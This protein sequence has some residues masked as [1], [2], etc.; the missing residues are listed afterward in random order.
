M[1]FL[2]SSALVIFG[3]AT[4][5]TPAVASDW[6][7]CT[8]GGC[9][10]APC[11]ANEGF[12]RIVSKAIDVENPAVGGTDGAIDKMKEYFLAQV[13]GRVDQG[14]IGRCSDAQESEQAANDMAMHVYET[15]NGQ[16]DRGSVDMTPANRV[17][18]GYDD[19]AANSSDSSGGESAVT[20][21]VKPAPTDKVA[22]RF[23]ATCAICWPNRRATA[24]R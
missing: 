3:T 8:V 23:L 6:R 22:A 4:I 24:T 14:P 13:N 2:I 5:A 17:F 18:A 19:A 16:Y 12:M 9:L 15:L 21:E 11:E 10:I 7:T 20:D 1:R